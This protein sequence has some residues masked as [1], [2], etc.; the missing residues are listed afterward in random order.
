VVVVLGMAVPRASAAEEQACQ[1]WPGE[2]SPLPS[3]ESRD[4]FEARWA[5]LRA[6]ELERLAKA[7]EANQP[8]LAQPLWSHVRCLDPRNQNAEQKA[9]ALRPQIAFSPRPF[10]IR[11][12]PTVAATKKPAAPDFGAIDRALGEAES[13][14]NQARFARAVEL[15]EQTRR[16]VEARGDSPDLRDRRARLEV[17]AATA[18]VALGRS[19][20]AADSFAR[21]LRA[22][23]ELELDPERTPPKI[24]RLFQQVREQMTR[25]GTAQR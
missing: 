20:D 16:D 9:Q 13:E 2:L 21:A 7:L 24:R 12:K 6:S 4:A 1:A 23:P 25:Q 14:L 15:T 3:T 10:V 22:D 11:A 17:I 8:G 5:T 18:L 19:E